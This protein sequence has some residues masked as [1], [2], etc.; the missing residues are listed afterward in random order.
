MLQLKPQQIINLIPEKSYF[1]LELQRG[2]YEF[3]D[4]EFELIISSLDNTRTYF[5]EVTTYVITVKL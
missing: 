2:S 3:D 1:M 5:T 4:D